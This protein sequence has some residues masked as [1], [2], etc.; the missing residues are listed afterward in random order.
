MTP[1]RIGSYAIER[2]VGRGGMGVVYLGRDAR[3]DR[4]VAIKI[5]PD[6]V[7]GDPDRLARFEREARLLAAVVHPNIAA[8]HGIEEDQG[9]R[10]L[11]L[12]YVEG[13]TL[14]QH[15]ARGPLPIDETIEV[16]RQVAAAVEAAHEVGIVHR[17]LKPGNVKLTPGGTVK[18][19]DFGLA[20]GGGVGAADSSPD[21]SQS[22]TLTVGAT[23]V[24]TILGT[25]AYMSPEQ[26][27]GKTVDR[28]TDI[29]SFG[30]VLYECLTGR[31]AFG[32]ETVS[33]TIAIIL[34]GQPDESRLPK[35]TPEKLR[36]LIAR[37]LEKDARKRLRDIGDA[38]LELEEIQASKISSITSRQ[39][40]GTRADAEA[41]RSRAFPVLGLAIAMAVAGAV[42]GFGISR[43]I[44][45]APL[46]ASLRFT[47]QP[48]AGVDLD[49]DPNELAISPDGKLLAFIG[50]DST[51]RGLWMRRMDSFDAE[52]LPGTQNA[53]QPFWTPDGRYLAFFND[54]KLSRMR[55]P[56][57]KPEQVCDA[58]SPRG[59]AWNARGILVYAPAA[60]GALQRLDRIGGTP[61]AVTV[62]DST[63]GET[64]HRWP[65]F[66]PDGDHF[67]YCALPVKDG[68]FEIHVGS[69][70]S[71][72]RV[73]VGRM[74]H[75]PRYVEPGYLVYE[76]GGSLLAQRF[77]ARKLQL[78]GDPFAIGAGPSAATNLS[79][80]PSF[81]VSATGVVAW[82]SAGSA[83]TRLVW[84]DRNGREVGTVDAPPG[85]WG[86]VAISPEG[87]RVCA[88]QSTTTGATDLWMIETERGTA[89][90]LTFGQG[91]NTNPLWMPD[92]RSILFSS[93]RNGRRD[94]FRRALD[95]PGV[96]EAFYQSNVTFKDALDVSPDGKLVIFQ[97][98]E[99]TNG[100]D[101]LTL[102]GSGGPPAPY[103]VTRFVES[104]P[105]ISPDG[106]WLVYISNESGS[107][108]A[109]VQSFPV[110]GHKQQVARMGAFFALW[111]PNGRE[112]ILIS[113][114]GKLTSVA[115][116]PGETLRF[117]TP[118]L[119]FRVPEAFTGLD[120]HPDG[121]FLVSASL[122]QAT[123]G[124]SVATGWASPEKR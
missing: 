2:E 72:Q 28:R 83:N 108:Q 67:L 51:H 92:G 89:T 20:K 65:S 76:R 30:C 24:G 93:T 61:T 113:E 36:H 114:A 78:V 42:V 19:L 23:G 104:F 68:E 82:V 94:I 15:L 116:E 54:G 60:T 99:G 29:W 88:E 26:A 4:P 8:I 91:D 100:W 120:I 63:A 5:L 81:T 22:P 80:S 35:K 53:S 9:R 75:S 69:L 77:D 118:R 44:G 47:I 46:P 86:Q 111:H 98:N 84:L 55:V 43:L 37:C 106:R 49:G 117:G 56:D 119:L 97:Q 45:N 34:Q 31:S 66:L 21:L 25:A 41:S 112:I 105:Q 74:G 62:V 59:S 1:S 13:E 73:H 87:R 64:A 95:G 101:L 103:L 115:V 57:G 7:A 11:V 50:S 6:L 96:D 70:S 33:D 121:R 110:P 85:Q 14:A 123:P 38:R 17:D 39:T 124:I 109:Y 90:R 27:R 32:G 79:A 40:F 18:V 58:P 71:K 10:F 102:P 48:P 12:E 122:V 3:L 52:L 107:V 16:C